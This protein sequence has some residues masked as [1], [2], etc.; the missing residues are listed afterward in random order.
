MYIRVI[1]ILPCSPDLNIIENIWSIVKRLFQI[2]DYPLFYTIAENEKNSIDKNKLK[3]DQEQQS[4]REEPPT[5]MEDIDLIVCKTSKEIS[6]VKAIIDQLNEANKK[7][8]EKPIIRLATLKPRG[9]ISPQLTT[10]T[11]RDY[12]IQSYQPYQRSL[13]GNQIQ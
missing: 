4:K 13:Q 1:F 2:E 8:L 12:Q 10:K 11:C 3:D 5:A 6:P 9:N 7:S